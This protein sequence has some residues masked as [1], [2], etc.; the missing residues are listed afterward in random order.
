MKCCDA[1]HSKFTYEID[2]ESRVQHIADV[3]QCAYAYGIDS[4]ICISLISKM[5]HNYAQHKTDRAQMGLN[6]SNQR[7]KV[8]EIRSGNSSLCMNVCEITQENLVGL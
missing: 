7:I 4:E 5:E 1:R 8:N 6:G 3:R 2:P